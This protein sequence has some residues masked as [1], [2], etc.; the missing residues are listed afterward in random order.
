MGKKV[1]LPFGSYVHGAPLS[2]TQA[3]GIA[4]LNH[5]RQLE[6]GGTPRCPERYL[7]WAQGLGGEYITAATIRP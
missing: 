4:I 5:A 7:V 1:M 3:R 6:R 2:P